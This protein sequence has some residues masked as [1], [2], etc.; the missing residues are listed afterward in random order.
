MYTSTHINILLWVWSRSLTLVAFHACVL[1]CTHVF[2]HPSFSNCARDVHHCM[3]ASVHAASP[4]LFENGARL[5]LLC[6]ATPMAVVRIV[7]GCCR[8]MSFL[9]RGQWES[10]YMYWLVTFFSSPL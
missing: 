8:C 1:A 9:L 6:T 4:A 2:S 7:A 10:D 3:R 5:H